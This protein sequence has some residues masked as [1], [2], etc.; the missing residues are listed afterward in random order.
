MRRSGNLLADLNMIKISLENLA[1]LKQTPNIELELLKKSID[2]EE[3]FILTIVEIITEI[4]LEL[5]LLGRNQ[6]SLNYIIDKFSSK[7]ETLDINQNSLHLF[8]LKKNLLEVYKNQLK[9]S[10]FLPNHGFVSVNVSD[11]T[12][13]EDDDKSHTQNSDF[14]SDTNL[15]K[16]AIDDFKNDIHINTIKELSYDFSDKTFIDDIDIESINYIL[17]TKTFNTNVHSNL[18]VVKEEEEED[19]NDRGEAEEEITKSMLK[20][21]TEEKICKENMKISNLFDYKP[22][23]IEFTVKQVLNEMIDSIEKN[24]SKT[25]DTQYEKDEKAMSCQKKLEENIFFVT[26]CSSKIIANNNSN[27]DSFRYIHSSK[28]INELPFIKVHVSNSSLIDDEKI[29]DSAFVSEDSRDCSSPEAINIEKSNDAIE[30]YSENN[31]NV[32]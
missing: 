4:E 27:E 24:L 3:E 23:S 14:S 19:V 26:D 25:P 9:W 17:M 22:D 2:N 6:T 18:E 12:E 7:L 10:Q 30:S 16:E 31:Q 5:E 29:T 20:E 32:S 8:Q 21:E 1:Q 11:S 15:D 28:E 13:E